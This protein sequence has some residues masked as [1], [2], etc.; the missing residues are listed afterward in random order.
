MLFPISFGSSSIAWV[1]VPIGTLLLFTLIFIAAL[2]RPGTQPAAV[3][4]AIFN[5]VMQALGVGLMSI[6]GIPACY[7]VIERLMM[8]Q[9]RFTTEIYVA[10][11]VLFAAGG[12]LFLW[13][14]DNGELHSP[15]Q[16][17]VSAIFL[18]MYRLIGMLLIII[19]G[20]SIV[21]TLL[22]DGAKAA[23]SWWIMP[24][25]LFLFGLLLTWC[26]PWPRQV[27]EVKME[28]LP[29]TREKVKPVKRKRLLA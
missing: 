27:V 26:V 10:L 9:E 5:H 29:E 1:V 17:V 7:A 15:S 28:R 20:L 16:S 2:L 13:H 24:G 25:L 12:L 14:E 4:R 23:P 11:L 3:G 21:L 19:F 6:S 8:N 18:S 22:F